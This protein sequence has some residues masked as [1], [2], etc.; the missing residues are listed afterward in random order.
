[1]YFT[2]F[3]SGRVY[4]HTAAF[5]SFDREPFCLYRAN[6]RVGAIH[7]E[8]T[9]SMDKDIKYAWSL[10][11]PSLALSCHSLALCLSN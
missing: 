1:M 11:Y 5:G 3:E 10:V 9:D 4:N 8:S 7:I 2:S 6:G